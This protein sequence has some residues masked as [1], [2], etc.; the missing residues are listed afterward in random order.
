M[1]PEQLAGKELDARVDLYAS[2]CVL[3]ECLAGK[4]PITADTPYQLVARLLEDVPEPVRTLNAEVPAAL[5]AL[6][7]QLLAKDPAA[8]PASALALHDRLAGIG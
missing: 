2:G 5:D 7:S 8:R 3:Y 1:A 4:P 6:I